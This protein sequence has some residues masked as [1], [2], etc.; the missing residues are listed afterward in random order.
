MWKFTVKMDNG[1][2]QIFKGFRVQHNNAR[3]PYKGG[4]RYHQNVSLDE[5]QAL[6][7][8]MSIKCAVANILWAGER[9]ALL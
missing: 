9:E 3:G 6:A 2:L 4:I 8:S 5:V 1:S 7:T